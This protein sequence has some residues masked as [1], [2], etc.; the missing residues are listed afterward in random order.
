[1]L[2]KT[3]NSL[4]LIFFSDFKNNFF[5]HW[6]VYTLCIN[7]CIDKVY[8]HLAITYL[9]DWWKSLYRFVRCLLLN[10]LHS[11]EK[12]AVGIYAYS[13]SSNWCWLRRPRCSQCSS[14]S[15]KKSSVRLRS[16]LCEFV[17]INL[18]KPCLH[19]P[20]LAQGHYHAGTGKCSN[21]MTKVRGKTHIR[22]W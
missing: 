11:S 5:F 10:T 14:S 22:V 4:W 7:I 6:I 1:M 19:G 20:H 8:R 15:Q 17:H 16:G 13:A 12:G 2:Q 21:F 9:C 18:G 3:I